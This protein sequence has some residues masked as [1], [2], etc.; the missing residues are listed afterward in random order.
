MIIDVLYKVPVF[1][2]TKQVS[3][4]I[5]AIC[6]PTNVDTTMELVNGNEHRINAI[7]KNLK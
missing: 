6:I 2:V 1:D 5:Q 4:I 3:K 7:F